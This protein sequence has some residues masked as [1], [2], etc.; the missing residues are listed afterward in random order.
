MMNRRKAGV[1]NLTLLA[2]IIA[3]ALVASAFL[4]LCLFHAAHE[5]SSH[6]HHNCLLCTIF[7]FAVLVVFF[8]D[9][10]A[11]LPVLYSPLRPRLILNASTF[12]SASVP[13]RAPPP[14][15]LI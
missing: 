14:N 10:F 15:K 2:V 1:Q 13:A 6:S 5:D 3:L 12:L 8:S 4:H 7:S 9:V 11:Y